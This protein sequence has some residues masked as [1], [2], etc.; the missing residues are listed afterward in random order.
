M[1]FGLEFTLI[2]CIKMLQN[3]VAM[4]HFNE[5]SLLCECCWVFLSLF[6]VCLY[7]TH[8]SSLI[9]L[10]LSS[11]LL[12]LVSELISV[13]GRHQMSCVSVLFAENFC[14]LGSFLFHVVY[15]SPQA[16]SI[17]QVSLRA[18]IDPYSSVLCSS[19]GPI[20]ASS[21]FITQYH[22]YHTGQHILHLC[23]GW[24]ID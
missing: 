9:C 6:S 8:F 5:Y 21:Q 19:E 22:T 13:I 15:K 4:A 2:A 18:V 11:H 17:P 14:L 7:L 16:F 10:F 3:C 12:T 1:A 20:L 23:L 24:F